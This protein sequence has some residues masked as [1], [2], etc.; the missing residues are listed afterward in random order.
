VVDEFVIIEAATTHNGI[1]KPKNFS[2]DLFDDDIKRKINYHFINFPEENLL[3]HLDVNAEYMNQSEQGLKSWARENFQRNAVM[4]GLFGA[5]ADDVVLLSDVDEIINEEAV[6]YLKE[7]PKILD[8]YPLLSLKQIPFFYSI[9]NPFIQQKDVRT[10]TWLHP[11]AM[12]AKVA[13]LNKPNLLRTAHHIG[14]VLDKA[15][16][17]F[18]YFGGESRVK[19]KH[20]ST[21]LHSTEPDNLEER[22]DQTV[23][24]MKTILSKPAE[25][26]VEQIRERY[27]LP[28][29][30]FSDKYKDFF[31][32]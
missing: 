24:T 9:T 22:S 5:K 27:S 7:N 3:K 2:M 8:E 10:E 16:W 6:Q 11:K 25:L 15:G 12:S 29:L 17:H 23:H 1:S 28:D 32:I 14:A 4:L 26:T 20:L 31:I 21:C 18:S 13:K 30:V 19:L